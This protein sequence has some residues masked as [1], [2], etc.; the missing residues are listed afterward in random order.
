M[1]TPDRDHQTL[2]DPDKTPPMSEAIHAPTKVTFFGAGS[3]EVG[4]ATLGVHIGESTSV[5]LGS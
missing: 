2:S 4:S 5:S 1:H 3:G